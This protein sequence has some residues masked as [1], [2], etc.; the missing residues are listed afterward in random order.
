MHLKKKK[1]KQLQFT[2]SLS[3]EMTAR[4][5]EKHFS[6]IKSIVSV[7][8]P[9]SAALSLFNIWRASPFPIGLSSSSDNKEN[10]VHALGSFVQPDSL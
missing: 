10:D 2:D 6:L 1:K 7:L 3:V 5:G 4:K 8:C 9:S